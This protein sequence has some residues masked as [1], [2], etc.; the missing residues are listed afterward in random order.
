MGEVLGTERNIRRHENALQG[1][2][3]DIAGVAMRVSHGFGKDERW[4]GRAA[5]TGAGAQ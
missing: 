3:T 1:P 5:E 4:R 2:I